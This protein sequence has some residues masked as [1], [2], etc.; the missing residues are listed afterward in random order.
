MERHRRP[1]VD[2]P[3]GAATASRS[4][5]SSRR[6]PLLSA[7]ENAVMAPAVKVVCDESLLRGSRFDARGPQAL[8]GRAQ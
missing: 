7:L 8:R 6:S 3:S 2:N 5:A 4:A 1:I